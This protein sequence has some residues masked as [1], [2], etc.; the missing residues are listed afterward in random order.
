MNKKSTFEEMSAIS[1]NVGL[2]ALN[3][4]FAIKEAKKETKYS[5][6]DFIIT[7][8]DGR[9]IMVEIKLRNRVYYSHL[10]EY[11]K[12]KGLRE[13]AS[14]LALNGTKVDDIWYVVINEDNM[15][16]FSFDKLN[17]LRNSG[18][19]EFIDSVM[20]YMEVSN[21]YEANP[22]NILLTKNYNPM[23]TATNSSFGLGGDKFI[24]KYVY[25]LPETSSI[26]AGKYK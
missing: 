10:M 16:V 22:D 20:G 4:V 17:V 8:E 25:F 24:E 21:Y 12:V 13:K 6:N 18:R 3:Y 26:F 1:D 19:Y 15:Y 7:L 11:K 14:K 5:R 23:Y 9:V 2:S